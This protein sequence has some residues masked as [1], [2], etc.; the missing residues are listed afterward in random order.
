MFTDEL[1]IDISCLKSENFT[2]LRDFFY[3]KYMHNNN[4]YS[5]LREQKSKN[6]NKYTKQTK[7]VSNK[8][9]FHPIFL[10]T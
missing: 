4:Y 5:S 3:N 8:K 9:L 2:I 10:Y 6:T 7:Y 1:L